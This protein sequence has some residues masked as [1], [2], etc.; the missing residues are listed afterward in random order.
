[1]A[2]SYH[3]HFRFTYERYTYSALNGYNPFRCQEFR[4]GLQAFDKRFKI[5]DFFFADCVKFIGV[6]ILSQYANSG[7]LLEES[8]PG[9]PL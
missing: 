9:I 6:E 8:V 1:M 7:T 3:P 5:A 4:Q 2:F